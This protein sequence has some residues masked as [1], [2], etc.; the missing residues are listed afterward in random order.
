VFKSYKLKFRT[1]ISSSTDAI[2]RAPQERAR[3]DC[4]DH[5]QTDDSFSDGDAH[6]KVKAVSFGSFSLRLSKEN[7]PGCRA[8]TRRSCFFLL[9]HKTI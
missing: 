9:E 5:I 1:K 6:R 2:E 8:G 7:E 3:T 4:T